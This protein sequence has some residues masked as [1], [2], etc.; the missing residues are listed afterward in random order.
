MNLTIDEA[1]GAIAMQE[2]ILE[3]SHFTNEDA[4]ELGNIIVG[5]IKR[6]EIDASVSI[7]LNNGYT[8]FKYAGN[9]TNL[10]NDKWL[11]KKFNTVKMT[12][13]STLHVC[14]LLEKEEETLA[15]WGLDSREYASCGGGFPIKVEE[16]GVIGSICIAGMEP[17]SEHDLLVK[18]ISKYLHVDEIPRIRSVI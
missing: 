2:E 9:N 13:K 15:D 7:K 18:C 12:E 1:I 17:V 3:F 6:L 14:L 16:V 8:V 5:A 4:W 11:D 10:L